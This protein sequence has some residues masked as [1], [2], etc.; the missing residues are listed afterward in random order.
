M[1]V[2]LAADVMEQW[3]GNPN[4]NPNCGKSITISHNGKTAQATIEDTCPGCS[5]NSLDLTPSLFEVF[6]DLSVGRVS[7]VEWWFN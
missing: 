1:I 5:G 4:L 3:T 6:A 7:G 2:A